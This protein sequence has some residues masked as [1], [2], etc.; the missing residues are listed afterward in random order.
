VGSVVERGG[1][2]KRET[3]GGWRPGSVYYNRVWCP[4]SPTHDCTVGARRVDID[5]SILLLLFRRIRV[6]RV[7]G[8]MSSGL[9]EC[10]SGL[11]RQGACM[12]VPRG[13]PHRLYSK[14]RH[15]DSLEG[16]S[17]SGSRLFTLPA[18]VIRLTAVGNS[19]SCDGGMLLKRR[20][21]NP[22]LNPTFMGAWLLLFTSKRQ[23]NSIA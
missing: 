8:G 17:G 23:Y 22:T 1:E 7:V 16:K 13:F 19:R 6:V 12:S 3:R 14:A 4:E 2:R 10:Q 18:P 21:Q 9:S 20:R 5:Q 15:C 11:D